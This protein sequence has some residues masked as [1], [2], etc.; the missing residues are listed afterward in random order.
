M[1]RKIGDEIISKKNIENY[2]KSGKIYVSNA[3]KIIQTFLCIFDL[4]KLLL[5]KSEN[6]QRREEHLIINEKINLNERI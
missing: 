1:Y 2:N 6:H 4:V 3:G 5:I